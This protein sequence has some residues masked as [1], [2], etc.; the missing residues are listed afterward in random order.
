MDG[1]PTSTASEN[2]YPFS[3]LSLWINKV[4]KHFHYILTPFLEQFFS[5]LLLLPTDGLMA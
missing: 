4:R 1:K 3:P 5:C 2:D